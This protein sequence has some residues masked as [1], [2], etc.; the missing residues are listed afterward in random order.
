MEYDG[1]G[2]TQKRLLEKGNIEINS[3]PAIIQIMLKYVCALT[4]S[5][6]DIPNSSEVIS[7][8]MGM[9]L[10]NSLGCSFL[11]LSKS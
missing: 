3:N 9:T 7:P 11:S 8:A 10:L 4:W 1:Y 5:F 2:L 6:S